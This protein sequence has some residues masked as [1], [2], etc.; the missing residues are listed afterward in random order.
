MHRHGW[1]TDQA[2][3]LDKSDGPWMRLFESHRVQLK[4]KK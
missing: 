4:D 3:E 1:I 2:E